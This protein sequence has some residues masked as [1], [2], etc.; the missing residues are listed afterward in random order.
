[1]RFTKNTR[2]LVIDTE[3]A[4][5]NGSDMSDVQIYDIGWAVCDIYGNVY[6][7]ASFVCSDIFYNEPELMDTA[8]Y[9]KKIPRYMEELRNGERQA[10][11]LWDIR[12]AMFDVIARYDIEYAAA[13]NAR[14]D[15][16]ALNKTARWV[17]KSFMRYFFRFNQIIWLDIMKMSQDAVV[18][19][20]NYKTWATERGYLTKRGQVRK[21]A[22][23]VFQYMTKSDD[24]AEEHTGLADVLIEVQIMAYC[25][26]ERNRRKVK[27]RTRLYENPIEY[28]EMTKFQ[29]ELMRSLKENPT[30]RAVAV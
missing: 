30:M 23:M 12:R 16:N 13:Y 4:N 29:Q 7:T 28:P 14:F 2:I 3:T 20:R 24:F 8:Y 17:S 1:M 6:E 18:S 19:T 22:E 21:T 11:T 27:M 9:A 5:T 26:A 10:A 25:F 15:A